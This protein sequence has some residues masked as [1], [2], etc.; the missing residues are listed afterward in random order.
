MFAIVAV[1]VFR[2]QL[3]RLVRTAGPLSTAKFGPFE[4]QWTQQRSEAEFAVEA[5]GFEPGAYGYLPNVLAEPKESPQ[6]A[7]LAAFVLI[8]AKLRRILRYA[9][10]PLDSNVGAVQLAREAASEGLIPPEIARAV[11]NLA[12]LRNLVLY[13]PEDIKPAHAKQY[14]ALADSVLF[15]LSPR[16]RDR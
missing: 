5:A 3:V 10:V 11:E 7:I 13:R 15:A 2:R 4:L 14:L 8:E 6:E 9:G 16:A 12:E 1:L